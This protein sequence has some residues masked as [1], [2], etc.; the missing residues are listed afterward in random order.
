MSRNSSVNKI[1]LRLPLEPSD[2]STL[3]CWLCG[4]INC[5]QEFTIRQDTP[6]G[7]RSTNTYGVH[8][9]CLPLL[10]ENEHVYQRTV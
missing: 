6:S 8:S 1:E 2:D 3:T 9:N 4:K 7:K 10:K 5:D